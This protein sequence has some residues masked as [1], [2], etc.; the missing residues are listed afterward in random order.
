MK[1]LFLM[2]TM[3]FN[4]LIFANVETCGGQGEWLGDHH[5]PSTV[6]ENCFEYIK[7]YSNSKQQYLSEGIEIY[8]F[9]NMLYID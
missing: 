2:M 4:F 6:D 7:A 9:K 1:N 8:G 5:N 3:T